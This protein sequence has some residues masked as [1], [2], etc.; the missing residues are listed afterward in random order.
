MHDKDVQNKN[1]IKLLKLHYVLNDAIILVI[2]AKAFAG[3]NM[4]HCDK[5]MHASF[6]IVRNWNFVPA[7]R[8]Y[9]W[10]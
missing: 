2:L 7:G 5:L 10:Q 3:I 6:L 9:S 4:L 8:A 1:Q